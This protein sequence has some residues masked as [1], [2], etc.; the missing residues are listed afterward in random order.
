MQRIALHLSADVM[1]LP[2][3]A[4]TDADLFILK[5]WNALNAV[6]SRVQH[7]SEHRSIGR[8]TKHLCLIELETSHIVVCIDPDHQYIALD[9]VGF[10]GSDPKALLNALTAEL[11]AA[12]VV[13]HEINRGTKTG[14]IM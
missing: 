7:I 10:E 6:G 14:L 11:P 2:P 1:G 8:H 13:V 4:L 12:Q 9:I 3:D 5:F